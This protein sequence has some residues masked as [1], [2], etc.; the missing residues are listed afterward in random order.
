MRL[1]WGAVAAFVVLA[2]CS[3]GGG[4]AGGTSGSDGH[5]GDASNGTGADGSGAST[6]SLTIGSGG[7][8]TGGND[9]GPPCSNDLKH[10]LDCGG[11]VV[12]TCVGLEGCDPLNGTCSNGCQISIDN[13]ESVGCEYYPTFMYNIFTN[14]CFAV[15]VA[16]TWHA[17]ANLDVLY[18]G[19]PL[20]VGSFAYIPQGSGPNLTYAPYDPDVGL[21]PGEVAILFL[22]GPTGVSQVPNITC[23]KAS[24]IESGVVKSGTTVADA[25]H[26]T[27]DVPVVAYQVNPYAGGNSEVTGASL[28]LPTSAWDTNYIA[29]NAYGWSPGSIQP[30][31]N[32]VAKDDNTTVTVVPKVAIEGGGGIPAG[33][34]NT[35]MSFTLNAGQ[36]AQI[37]QADELTGSVLDSDK[38]IG[39]LAGHPC[40]YVPTNVTACDHG[41]QMVPPVRALGSEYVGV[42]HRP[43]KTEPAHWRIIGAVDGT[44]LSWNTDVGGPATLQQ[45]DVAEFTTGTPFVVQSQDDDHPFMLFSHMVGAAFQPDLAGGYGDSDTVISVPT[46]QYMRRYVFFADPTY[47]ETNLVMVRSKQGGV[48][49]DV[50]LDCAGVI[51]GWSA[52]GDYEWARVDL[53]TGDFQNVGNCSTGR[54]EIESDGPFGL[55]IWGWGTPDTTEYTAWVSYGYPAG[56]NVQYI[57]EV[58]VPPV[59]K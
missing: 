56:M 7:S 49:H 54:H 3:A 23:P 42:M 12:D 34:A 59:P 55:W 35:A 21:P 20:D 27:T 11:S 52:V 57:N 53:V 2:A 1:T 4:S 51:D 36:H 26:L 28:L 47:P 50:T 9:C 10:V 13:K 24:A 22:S 29:A 41:E 15:F 58:V 6:G 33:N 31:L 14:V 48:F 46:Q 19:S 40:H 37:T 39:L 30:S 25:F 18:Q 44:T 17:P 8:G 16:N 45:G 43:R 38:P 32:I 5:G